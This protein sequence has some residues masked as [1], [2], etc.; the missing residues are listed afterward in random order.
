MRRLWTNHIGG[1]PVHAGDDGQGERN[2][3]GNIGKVVAGVLGGLIA[4]VGLFFAASAADNGVYYGGLV[5]FIV[6]VAFVFYQLKRGLD[7]MEESW[8]KKAKSGGKGAAKASS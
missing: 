6:G 4:L 3:M 8:A 1:R 2:A 5:I 7:D